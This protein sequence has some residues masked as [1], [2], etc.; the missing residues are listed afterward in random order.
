MFCLHRIWFAIFGVMKNQPTLL[1]CKCQ[2]YVVLL[3]HHWIYISAHLFLNELQSHTFFVLWDNFLI[4]KVFC[5][6]AVVG[7]VLST[8]LTSLN[9]Y[10][11]ILFWIWPPS[12]QP[13]MVFR[14]NQ[15]YFPQLYHWQ[16]L[17][18]LFSYFARRERTLLIA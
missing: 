17:Q 16:R 2:S 15:F 8:T 1:Q 4:Q 9:Q 13:V 18:I 10:R 6:Q 11:R 3:C 5:W 14:L 12:Q 7:W